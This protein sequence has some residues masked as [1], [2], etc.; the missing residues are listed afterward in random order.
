MIRIYPLSNP[1]LHFFVKRPANMI[2]IATASINSIGMSFNWIIV[3]IF[4]PPPA[5]DTSVP[6]A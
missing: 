1:K 4:Y 2:A 5:G 6:L 3:S